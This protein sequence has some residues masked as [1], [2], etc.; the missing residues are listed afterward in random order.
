MLVLWLLP[1][2]PPS[3]TAVASS[4]ERVGSSSSVIVPVPVPLLS[5]APL[6]LLRVTV[7]ASFGSSRSSSCVSTSMNCSLVPA[8]KVSGPD[9]ET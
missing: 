9:F 6:G 3:T 5:V 4:M 7:N 8:E 1:P 2:L